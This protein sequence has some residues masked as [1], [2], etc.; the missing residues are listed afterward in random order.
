MAK[1][2]A[3]QAGV[4]LRPVLEVVVKTR[5]AVERLSPTTTAERR[6]IDLHVRRLRRLEATIRPWCRQLLLAVSVPRA[7][8]R[9]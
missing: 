9:K 1:K 7:A 5:C 6:N 2:Q 8:R 4:S 3:G